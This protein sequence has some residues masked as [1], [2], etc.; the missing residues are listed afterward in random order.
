MTDLL[1]NSSSVPRDKLSGY[2]DELALKCQD[3]QKHVSDSVLFLTAYS[4]GH[5]QQVRVCVQWSPLSIPPVPLYC[6]N[7]ISL[8]EKKINMPK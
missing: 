4:L 1:E 7:M 8:V 2:F 3:L 5:Y 6:M